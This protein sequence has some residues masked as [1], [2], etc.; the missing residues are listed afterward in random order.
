MSDTEN[1]SAP[2]DSAQNGAATNGQGDNK[3]GGPAPISLVHQ[4]VKDLS[5]ENPSTPRLQLSPGVQ[6]TV[7]VKVDVTATKLDEKV[8]EVALHMS[9]K[10]TA[11]EHVIYLGELVY[12]AV[13][14]IENVRPQDLEP[15][16]LIEVPRMMFPYARSIISN[17]TRDGGFQPL[18]LNPFDFMGLYRKRMEGR[19][20][21]QSTQTGNA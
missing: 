3:T 1:K 6:P 4:Y 12:A 21:Q 14:H 11:Q 15:V 20:A 19:S 8:F 10:T 5:F 16:L 7:D 17:A 9:F 2:Q 13:V 18:L